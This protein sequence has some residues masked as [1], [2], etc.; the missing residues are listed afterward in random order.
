LGQRAFQFLLQP[1]CQRALEPEHEESA[2]KKESRRK[3]LKGLAITLPAAWTTPM[4]EAIVLPAHAATSPVDCTAPED[5][6]F[7][8]VLERYFP[9][10]GGTESRLVGLHVSECSDTQILPVILVVVADSLAA[11][12]AALDCEENE[13]VID[14]ETNPALANGCS[15]YGCV[16]LGPK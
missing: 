15:F 2:M 12:Q 3:L 11:A 14:L 5:C 1:G 10:P 6:Y 4:V 16:G 7:S 13:E 9:W 8:Q